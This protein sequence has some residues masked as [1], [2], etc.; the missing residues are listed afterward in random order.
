MYT[1]VYSDWH[2]LRCSEKNGVEK[3]AVTVD[4]QIVSG[5]SEIVV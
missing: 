5:V 4:T 2:V 1:L 3:G